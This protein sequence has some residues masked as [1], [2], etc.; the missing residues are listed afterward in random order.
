MD[1]PIGSGPWGLSGALRVLETEISLD[2]PAFGIEAARDISV[3][4]TEIGLRYAF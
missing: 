1:V 2:S 3:F 4:S